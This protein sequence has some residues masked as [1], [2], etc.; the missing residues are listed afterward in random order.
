MHGRAGCDR[1]ISFVKKS[2]MRALAAT[3]L[4]RT[5]LCGLIAATGVANAKVT[6]GP[7]DLT[8]WFDAEFAAAM[9]ARK[10]G[11]AIVVVS[12]DGHMVLN[13]GY[14]LDE[15]QTDVPLDAARTRVRLAS[16]SKVFTA[17]AIVQLLQSG[18]I[19]SLDAPAND[20]LR[21]VQLAPN[22]GRAITIRHLLTHT[23]GFEDYM[24]GSSTRTAVQLPLSPRQIEERI[25]AFA[26]PVGQIDYSNA[27]FGILGVLIEDV[28]GEPFASYLSEHVFA[29]LG[30]QDS[31]VEY[32]LSA[33][34]GLIPSR[35]LRA[36]GGSEPVEWMALHPF[37]APAGAIISTGSDMARF[38]DA[39]ARSAAAAD[40]PLMSATAQD[41]MF[42]QR[43][44]SYPGLVGIGTAYFTYVW[45]GERVIEHGGDLPGAHSMLVMLPDSRMGFFISD[46]G[47]AVSG[48]PSKPSKSSKSKADAPPV[49]DYS[50]R[51]MSFRL[52]EHLLGP[53]QLDVTGADGGSAPANPVGDYV[54]ARSA[55]E[56]L[57]MPDEA[58]PVRRTADG[59]LE[60]AGIGALTPIAP[61]IYKGPDRAVFN[62]VAFTRDR[63]GA[64]R[65]IPYFPFSIA[66]RVAGFDNP[67]VIQRWTMF[68]VVALLT[69]IIALWWPANAFAP[70]WAKRL[71][72]IVI[73]LLALAGIVALAP[74]SHGASLLQGYAYGERTGVLLFTAL[75]DLIC[76]AAAVM[77]GVQ[78]LAWKRRF[79]GEGR[80]GTAR[81]VH[82]GILAL[83]AWALIPALSYMNVLGWP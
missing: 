25:P 16:I 70:L 45:N 44:S 68:G 53:R 41:A 52:L 82:F 31:S 62:Y 78:F 37:M 81:R 73:G 18:A 56:T 34:P 83:A 67:A 2:G 3:A 6:A 23:A 30:M 15:L 46:A 48:R 51:Q 7:A 43:A 39:A 20:Y 42:K 77:A 33:P 10:M 29:P 26:R 11:A 80:R 32:G 49:R 28:T 40:S 38:I 21:R 60:L 61:G 14:E 5:V 9:Q 19:R 64:Q 63:S 36:D 54:F 72:A 58:I 74:L 71:P 22:Q 57:R 75:A 59:G 76:I 13:K 1:R 65:L 12:Q 8:H 79:W 27:G 50:P 24:F 4:L 69:G 17:T 55:H 47:E 66:E 35:V